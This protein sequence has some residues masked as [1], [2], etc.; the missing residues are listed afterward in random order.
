MM[1]ALINYDKIL[2]TQTSPLQTKTYRHGH[3]DDWNR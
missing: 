1:A 2:E 3:E